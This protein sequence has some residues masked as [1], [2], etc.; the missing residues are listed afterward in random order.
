[1]DR[2]GGRSLWKFSSDCFNILS[3]LGIRYSA[4][5]EGAEEM[6]EVYGEGKV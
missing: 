5:S 2:F 3:E 1:M 6:M 4:E